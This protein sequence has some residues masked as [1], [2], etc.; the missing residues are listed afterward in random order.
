MVSTISMKKINC[1]RVPS[2]TQA[3]KTLTMLPSFWHARFK[4]VKQ[5]RV[6]VSVSQN[7]PNLERLCRPFAE[8]ALEPV[9]SGR[10]ELHSVVVF[11]LAIVNKN[12]A[13]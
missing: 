1:L 5:K 11:H 4:I 3:I 13:D 7:L 2:D 12:T 9:P 6:S 8:R 10:N